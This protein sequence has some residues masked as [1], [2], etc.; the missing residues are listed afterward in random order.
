MVVLKILIDLQHFLPYRRCIL[1]IHF[2]QFSN[3]WYMLKT[4][5]FKLKVSI[6][7]THFII[8][9][10]WIYTKYVFW[11]DTFYNFINFNLYYK[12]FLN[13]ILCWRYLFKRHLLQFQNNWIYTKHVFLKRYLLQFHKSWYIL[14]VSFQKKPSTISQMLIYIIS[15]SWIWFYIESVFQ[16]TPS[17]IP[18]KLNLY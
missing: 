4:I 17:T 11:K 9:K 16:K 14:K 6:Q 7:E 18:K 5:E 10:N 8:K 3:S 1:K 2:L 13:L 12:C 15:I